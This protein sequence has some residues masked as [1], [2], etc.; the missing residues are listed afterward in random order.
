MYI[1]EIGHAVLELLSFKGGSGNHQRGLSL[2]LIDK[3]CRYQFDRLPSPPPP[4]H[5][6]AFA[7]KCLPSPRVFAQQKMPGDQA[8]K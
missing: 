8:N 2:L 5:P 6:R 3:L 7:P 4:R 1:S